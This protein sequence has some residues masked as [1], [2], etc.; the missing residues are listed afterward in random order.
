MFR[1]FL[2]GRSARPSWPNSAPRC[3]R[4]NCPGIG[5]AL[6]RF[7]T[8]TDNGDSLPWLSECRN[9]KSVTLDMRTPDGAK[10]LKRLVEKCRRDG[11]ELPARHAGEVGPGLGHAQG[12]QSPADHGAHLRLWPDRPVPRS[13]RV[14][15]H[16]QCLRRPVLPG[17]LSRPPA[18]DAGL[19]HHPGLHGGPLRGDGRD[20]RAAGARAHRPRPDDRHR[21]VRADLPHPGRDRAGLW[22]S[23]AWCAS[24]WGPAPSTWCRTATTRPRTGAGSRSPAPPTRS[25]SAWPWRWASRTWRSRRTGAAGQPRA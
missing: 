3:S 13:A 12:G 5:D 6:R 7:G 8:I 1:A 11:R 17:R 22:L 19:G 23:R 16:R 14:R 15:S 21:P 9:K 2:P 18:R 4:W 10:I 20:A 24:A 25:T